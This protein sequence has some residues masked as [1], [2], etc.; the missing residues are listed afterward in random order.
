MIKSLSANVE[1]L[2]NKLGR[3]PTVDEIAKE[4]DIT[5]ENVV[6]LLGINP[7]QAYRMLKRLTDR[8]KLKL[9]GSGRAA[10]YEMV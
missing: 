5:R 4:L 7:S 9:V 1:E 8:G 6:D 2:Q 3:E 10:H